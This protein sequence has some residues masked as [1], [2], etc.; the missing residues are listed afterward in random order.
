M[1]EMLCYF[2]YANS[3]LLQSMIKPTIAVK[4]TIQPRLLINREKK[5]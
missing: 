3:P 5:K 4:E 1:T 2:L